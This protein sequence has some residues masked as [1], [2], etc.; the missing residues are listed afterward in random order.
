SDCLCNWIRQHFKD[1]KMVIGGTE[2]SLRRFVHYDYWDNDLR[3]PILFDSRADILIYG[4][5]EKQILEIAKKLK[6]RKG[7][8]S[9]AGTCIIRKEVPKGFVLLPNFDE[10]MKSKEKFCEMQNLFSN[11]KNLAQK[12][13][14]RFVL[15]YKSPKYTSQDLDKYYELPF[16]RK[17]LGGFE[18][19]VVTHRGC[20][21]ECN[22]CALRLL[23]GNRIISR[24]EKSILQEI[25]KITKMP[26]FK[27][28]IDDLGG[29]SANMYGMDCY[30]CER[31]CI[32]CNKLDRSNKRLIDLLRKAREIKGVK[33]IIVRSG[34]RYDLASLNYIK[35]MGKYHLLNTLRIAPEHVNK[36]V[37]RLMNKDKGDLQKFICDFNKTGRKLSFYF[38]T[39]HPGS[40]MKEAKELAEAIK[41]LK[42]AETVQVF[43]PTPMTISTCMY[44]T[45][46]E[47]K[48]KKK[49]YVPYT[50]REKKEQKRIIFDKTRN[51]SHI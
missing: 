10:V 14:N 37:L 16:T 51:G 11:N 17:H 7:L 47:P 19:S 21:G 1:S 33:K 30:Q 48:T 41:K 4:N 42:N 20:I 40:T 39:A 23:Q 18:F 13:D 36:K 45:G 49:V 38:M 9:V 31:S 8:D 6:E 43:I 27:G 26:H 2:A 28:N 22:F 44:W 15:Q 25:E 35:E 29:P 46:L 32:D 12:I 5:A 50:Y 34:I 24:S 3:K